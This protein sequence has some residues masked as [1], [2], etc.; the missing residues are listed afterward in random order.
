MRVKFYIPIY[1]M[2]QTVGSIPANIPLYPNQ[3]YILYTVYLHSLNIHGIYWD[4]HVYSNQYH[5]S[6]SLHPNKHPITSQC[7]STAW[8]LHILRGT[9]AHALT[10]ALKM[11]TSARI[12]ARS[13]LGRGTRDLS[14]DSHGESIFGYN[15]CKL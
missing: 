4:I 3:Y 14:M 13:I 12:P 11:R 5:I 9:C 6:H 10:A 15:G 2:N 8:Y 1:S 7:I